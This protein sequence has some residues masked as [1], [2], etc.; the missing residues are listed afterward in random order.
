MTS[1][2][3]IAVAAVAIA[4]VAAGAYYYLR[5]P[6]DARTYQGWVEAQLIN[7]IPD[8]AGRGEPHSV[9]EGDA[10]EARAPLFSLDSDLQRA[11]VA[12]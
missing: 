1:A 10:I 9:R 12:E 5:A 2:K 11:A 6:T 3:R 4:A 7:V 8:E